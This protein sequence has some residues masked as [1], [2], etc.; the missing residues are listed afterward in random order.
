M[1][2][3]HYSAFI[4]KTE[5]FAPDILNY[6]IYSSLEVVYS[7]KP[8]VSSVRYRYIKECKQTFSTIKKALRQKLYS[9]TTSYVFLAVCFVLCTLLAGKAKAKLCHVITDFTISRRLLS[10]DSLSQKRAISFNNYT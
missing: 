4:R 3:Y 6:L 10:S 1:T 9:L 7:I 5:L 8:S 2:Y